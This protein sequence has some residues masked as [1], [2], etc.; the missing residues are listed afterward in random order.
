MYIIIAHVSY[1][2]F[3]VFIG[4]RERALHQPRPSDRLMRMREIYVNG[5][6]VIT[7]VGTSVYWACAM[8]RNMVRRSVD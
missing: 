5:S 7:I 8:S 6:K 2:M 4:E 3:C 1:V